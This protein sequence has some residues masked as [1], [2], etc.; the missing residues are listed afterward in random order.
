MSGKA[1]AQR[2]A[3]RA[4]VTRSADVDLD[5]VGPAFYN[6]E[7][8]GGTTDLARRMKLNEFDQERGLGTGRARQGCCAALFGQDAAHTSMCDLAAA[9]VSVSSVAA[10]AAAITFAFVLLAT[11]PDWQDH[12]MQGWQG[13]ASGVL[14]LVGGCVG[15]AL[16]RRA[17]TVLAWV[18]VV[19]T[20]AVEAAA[21]AMLGLDEWAAAF[22]YVVLATHIAL[23]AA[24]LVL[25]VLLAIIAR[26]LAAGVNT[27]GEDDGPSVIPS[28][29][30]RDQVAYNS[31]DWLRR[32]CCSGWN[33]A[34]VHD[35][36]QLA[37]RSCARGWLSPGSGVSRR[38][39]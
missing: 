37:W 5:V 21:L 18:A 1:D 22:S 19:V 31:S 14:I 38:C 7:Q 10:G 4:S 9:A 15:V 8:A 39:C 33:G 20:L 26:T 2:R 11:S 12:V 3:F 13:A 17:R 28:A 30:A 24:T 29:F 23:F 35:E 34:G 6:A 25:F 32:G 36:S 27:D 16:A